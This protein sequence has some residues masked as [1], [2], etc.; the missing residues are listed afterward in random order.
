M[1]EVHAT[2]EYA[3]LRYTMCSVRG[4]KRKLTGFDVQDADNCPLDPPPF[5]I[6]IPE[7]DNIP[8]RPL[9]IVISTAL[10]V[11]QSPDGKQGG[12]QQGGRKRALLWHARGGDDS[13]EGRC[14]RGLA[15]LTEED[16]K[17]PIIVADRKGIACRHFSYNSNPAKYQI[18]LTLQPGLNHLMYCISTRIQML[19][20]W[21]LSITAKTLQHSVKGPTIYLPRE[22][23]TKLSHYTYDDRQD[24]YVLDRLTEGHSQPIMNQMNERALKEGIPANITL[25]ASATAPSSLTMLAT[26][27]AGSRGIHQQNKTLPYLLPYGKVHYNHL[28]HKVICDIPTL[29]PKNWNGRCYACCEEEEA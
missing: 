9:G 29:P 14:V 25:V 16:R 6:G 8:T 22:K 18:P 4:C 21:E 7:S 5:H 3:I 1:L 26:L 27:A 23:E 17:L 13:E 28:A 10:V 19:R 15:F 11:N 12:C 2:Y 20:L 24:T